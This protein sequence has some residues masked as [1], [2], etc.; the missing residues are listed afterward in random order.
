M[1][2]ALQ[3]IPS[4]D[5]FRKLSAKGNLI[6]LYA[7]MSSD[8]Y[9]PVQ[10]FQ[11]LRSACSFLLESAERTGQIGRYSF[12]GRNPG[13]IFR[14][15]GKTITLTEGDHIQSFET[16]R[17][18]LF[19]LEKIMEQYR[20][21]PASNL[22][23]FIGG[24]VGYLGYDI[25]R[26][27]EETK[28]KA[29]STEALAVP[30]SL[31]MIAKEVV[32]L[33]HLTHRLYLI[34]NAS[35]LDGDVDGAYEKA[36]ERIKKLAIDLRAPSN[37]EPVAISSEPPE[38]TVTS[39]IEEERFKQ[40]VARA[41]EY[42]ISGDII[43]V[44]LSQRFQAEYT[45]DPLNLYRTLWLVNPSPYMF[46]ITFGEK[47][48]IVGS[49]PEVHVRSI[50]GQ[51]VIRPIAGTEKRGKTTEEDQ[52]LE[53][54]LLANPKE[55]AEHVMLLDLARNDIGRIA[56]FGSVQV[57]EKFGIER[58][59]HVM[60]I[61]SNVVGQKRKEFTSYDVMRASFPAGT[62]SGAPKIRAMQIISELEMDRR[63]VYS[64]A[65]GYFGFNGNLD[66]CIALRT[67]VIKDGQAYVQAG[68]G[69]VADSTPEGE[70]E[71][72]KNKAR[73][74]LLAI[75]RANQLA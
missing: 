18:P 70:F 63:G 58:F 36:C 64:G 28:L 23:P 4:R 69:I 14:S 75:A 55:Q 22:P 2:T 39:N 27:F 61:A 10:V 74:M 20:Y 72:T 43:Q 7:I 46:C 16:K 59:S 45:G 24:A 67:V 5:E 30:E 17:D 1:K 60:H 9:T 35:I 21:V 34:S 57:T 3:I 33:D 19:E 11:K 38:F 12:V 42:I 25:V 73:G 15:N 29:A 66:S 56:E 71:E 65:V 49:S 54:K 40:M 31:F 41:K 47:F 48:A 68:A 52:A 50:N 53:K 44:V 37:L 51:V 32:C 26:F 8:S 6:P 62:V 13:I